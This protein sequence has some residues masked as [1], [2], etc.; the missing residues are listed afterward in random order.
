MKDSS[1]LTVGFM[2]HR[3]DNDYA[4]SLLNGAAAA[5]DEADVNLVIFPGR[6]INSQL[7][8]TRYTA[9]EY[10]NNVVYSYISKDSLDALVI[11]AGTVGSFI[12][13]AE[14]DEYI[15]RY[16]DLPVLTTETKVGDRPCIR[17]CSSGIK[18]V[19][20]HLIK[21]HGRRK[22]AFVSGP[23]GNADAN[24]RLGYY[25]EALAENGIEFDPHLVAYGKFSEYCVDL[26]GELL[27]NNPDI[28]AICFANDMMCKGGYKAIE[29][30]GLTVGKDIS[31][32][33]YD[34]SEVATGIKPML[35]TVRADASALG[36]SAVL[37]AVDIARGKNTEDESL[38]SSPVY[39]QSCGCTE[40]FSANGADNDTGI[41]NA[42]DRIIDEHLV[43]NCIADSKHFH[44]EVK[45]FV[46]T[47]LRAASVDDTDGCIKKCGELMHTIT[48]RY[49]FSAIAPEALV[50]T[51]NAAQKSAVSLCASAENTAA[52]YAISSAAQ[53]LITE[54]T[55]NMHY[56]A[57]NDMYATHFLICNITKDMTMYGDNEEK[58][59]FSIVNNLYRIH[60]KSSFIYTYSDA[61]MHT[62]KMQWK[63]PD[64]IYL[65]SCHDGE[66][67]TAVTGDSQKMP[68]ADFFCNR[69][70][71]N[72]RRTAVVLPLYM[73]EEQFGIMVSEMDNEYFPFVY[74]ITP[75]ICTAIKLTRLVRQLENLLNAEYNRNNALNRISMCDELTGVY[76]RRGFYE[77]TNLVLQAPE[78][79]GKHAV[80]VFGDL[81]NLKK[82]NDTFGHDD[83]DYAIAAAAGYLKSGFRQTDIVARIGGDEFAAF[84]VCDNESVAAKLPS[85]IKKIAAARNAAS[86]KPFN[87][88]MSVGIYPLIC[89]PDKNIQD[90]MDKADAALYND[91]KNKDHNILKETNTKH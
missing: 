68:P 39:R 33:G 40:T 42:A 36:Y 38:D 62:P 22:I 37:K 45:E 25:K 56:L 67:L 84:A 81:D 63:L 29:A 83:G 70:T 80:L 66:Q 6:S 18:E 9:Y 21:E 61:V 88:N 16:G 15:S 52:V 24:E 58:C 59:Y 26:V 57:I 28:D 1:R 13:E 7:D 12:S 77:F 19:I 43:Q 44:D 91:K 53:A 73:S 46:L 87:V 55:I 14:F 65:K 82:I 10:Q 86:D 30:R 20:A 47:M 72:R 75:Q 85:R 69:F 60:M 90:F 54:R 50:K 64:R 27:D 89:S 71:P 2:I 31:I 48:E 79:N 35:T 11:S 3:L 78:N 5:A 74:S 51:V 4:K 8:D 49:L 32:T 17:L 41:E 34:D 76:N 23:A